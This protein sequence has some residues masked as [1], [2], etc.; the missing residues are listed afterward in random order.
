M[1][2][3]NGLFDVGEVDFK[4]TDL[5]EPYDIIL[6]N[7]F[8]FCHRLLIRLH[9]QAALTQTNKDRLPGSNLFAVVAGPKTIV[10][11]FKEMSGKEKAEYLVPTILARNKEM[12]KEKQEMER[13]EEEGEKMEELKKRL[14]A[15]Y[16]GHFPNRLPNLSNADKSSVR[17]QIQIK[18]PSK[19][20]NQQGYPSPARWNAIWKQVLDEHVAA[21]RL[22]LSQSPYA[23]P[24]FIQPKK[25]P[26]ADPQ[27]LNN[28]RH[29]NENT[30]PD[31]TPLPL[32]DEILSTTATTQFWG[33][34]DMSDAFFK[35]LMAEED[36]EK[37]AIKTPWGLYEWF[38][39]P[40]GLCNAPATHQRTV[41]KALANLIGVACFV[42]VDN[43]IIYSN[44]PEEHEVNCRR[45]L[46][47]LQRAGLYC[48]PKKTNLATIDTE[49]LGH[50]ITQGGIG[51]DPNKVKKVQNWT[52]PCTAK[53]LC[54]ILG[55][56]QYLRKFIKLLA[57]HTAILTPLTKKGLGP[58]SH[59]G[60]KRR[61]KLS[62]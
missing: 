61:T 25:D 32:P 6:G 1:R 31:L 39:M 38:V 62:K 55:L 9:P 51:A 30:V 21:S 20:H 48:S 59:F 10:E 19:T 45:V 22:R 43:I 54:G 12:G 33:K 49:F 50:W 11:A 29:L 2:T 28:Y 53:E 40:Q 47:A 35:T 5:S 57:K 4:V 14:M 3:E 58:S 18:D 44:T 16:A 36:I 46:D 42:F 15:E 27:W 52:T 17:H 26:L 23:L 24:S 13:R 8:L 56:V 41:N 7:P 37:T 60:R 34:I